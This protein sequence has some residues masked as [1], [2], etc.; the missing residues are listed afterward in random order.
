MRKLIWLVDMSLDGF[1]SGPNGELDWM[2]NDVDD[3]MWQDVNDL[4]STVDTALFGR[5]TYQTFE[6]YWPAAGRNPVSPKNELEF[7]RWIERTPKVV[8]SKSLTRLEWRNSI[9]VQ[10][11]VLEGVSQIK[12]ESGRDGLMFGSCSLASCLLRANLIDELQLRIHPVVLGLGVPAFKDGSVRHRP[13]L[14]RS[15]AFGSGLVGLQYKMG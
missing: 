13:K 4:L 14:V 15:R 3:E 11:D 2:A 9:L 1:M 7:S 6:N 8:A 12:R 10:G 5:R